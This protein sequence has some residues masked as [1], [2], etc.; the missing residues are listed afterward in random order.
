[1]EGGHCC[2]Q[3]C[4]C[5]VCVYLNAQSG[6]V[7][8]RGLLL[9]AV[10]QCVCVCVFECTI[11]QHVPSNQHITTTPSNLTCIWLKEAFTQTC[12]TKSAHPNTF[13]A[14]HLCQAGGGLHTTCAIKSAHPTHRTCV[15]PKAAV[16]QS[17]AVISAHPNT[18]HAPHLC[19]AGGS[20]LRL[21]WP[22]GP[23]VG[24]RT[25]KT[26]NALQ[27]TLVSALPAVPPIS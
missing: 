2:V 27:H 6:T 5:A 10:V 1:M 21:P 22:W 14:P 12:A 9:C 11:W 3:L 24:H 20:H 19:Q 18:L 17:R 4:S 16:T 25:L 13:H 15:R 23:Q 8:G 26:Q 7:H